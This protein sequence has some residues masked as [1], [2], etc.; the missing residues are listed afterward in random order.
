MYKI[1]KMDEEQI[2]PS[3]F[4]VL[5]S[6]IPRDKTED[7]L[8][9]YLQS[10]HSAQNVKEVIYCYDIDK[11]IS[12][13]REKKK[14]EQVCAYVYHLDKCCEEAID[15]HDEHHNDGEVVNASRKIAIEQMENNTLPMEKFC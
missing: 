13:I 12:L 7:E 6:N 2:T 11:V 1:K 14:A 15:E 3:D 9:E 4:A 8:K 10:Q 5:T